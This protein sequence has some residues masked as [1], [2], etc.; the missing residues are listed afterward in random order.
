MLKNYNEFIDSNSK[1]GIISYTSYTCNTEI[2]GMEMKINKDGSERYLGSVKVGPKGQIVI[3]K[4]VRDMFGIEPGMTMMVLADS[5]KG[6]ALERFSVFNKIADAIFKGHAK[7]IYPE[8]SEEDS[9][10]FASVIKDIE[11]EEK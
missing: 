1:N 2:E 10:N 11:E 4:E 6:I 7:E 9:L 5:Q 8:N 3:P